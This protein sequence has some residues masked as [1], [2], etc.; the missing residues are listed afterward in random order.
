MARARTKPCA[1]A[2]KFKRYPRLRPSLAD[3]ALTRRWRLQVLRRRPLQALRWRLLQA[4]LM[5]GADCLE[6]VGCFVRT[7]SQLFVTAGLAGQ[8]S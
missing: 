6:R 7:T 1:L 8:K 4:L 2:I 3:F 5:S